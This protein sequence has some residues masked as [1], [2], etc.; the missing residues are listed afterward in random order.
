MFTFKSVCVCL[1][2]CVIALE[3]HIVSI[4]ITNY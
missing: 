2:V 1:C 4:I 3:L